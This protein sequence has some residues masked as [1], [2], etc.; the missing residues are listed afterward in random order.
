MA[1]RSGEFAS[2]LR[3]FR[4]RADLSQIEL[5]KRIGVTKDSIGN[6]EDGKCMPSFGVA[7]RMAD[8]LGISLDQLAGRSTQATA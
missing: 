2:N 6:W 1:D 5:A 4:A 3:A 8:E 7:V